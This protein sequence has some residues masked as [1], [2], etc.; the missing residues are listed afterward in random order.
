MRIGIDFDNTI[1][2]YD[3]VFHRAAV[4]R[5]LIEEKLGTDKNTV[6]NYLREIGKEDD[7][8]ELQ[9]Y[10]YGARMD[11]VAV[12]EGF[13]SF[14]KQA[15]QLDHDLVI[16]SHKTR[17]PFMGPPYDL[18][19][20]AR[21][22]LE[23][24]NVVSPEH[25]PNVF[26]ELTLDEKVARI[27]SE[28]CDIFIDDLPELLGHQQFPRQVRGLLFDPADHFPGGVANGV[29]YEVHPDWKS[30]SQTLLG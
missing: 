27:R 14:V 10:V 8:T 19:D 7:W 30:I 18:H 13:L 28:G 23:A 12:Y 17:K 3:G 2:C 16:I 22:F 21:S 5:G 29:T 11:L 6:R 9:G 4:E 25:V 15:R 24:Q 1:A 20:A 26:F